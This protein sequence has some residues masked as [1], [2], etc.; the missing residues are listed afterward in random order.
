MAWGHMAVLWSGSRSLFQTGI[1]QV[2]VLPGL[3]SSALLSSASSIREVLFLH[4]DSVAVDTFLNMPS[5]DVANRARLPLSVLPVI[6]IALDSS[7]C[8]P[9]GFFWRG[10]LNCSIWKLLNEGSYQSCSHRPMPQPEQCRIQAT[11][12]TYAAAHGNPRSLTH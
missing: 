10:A 11:S 6:Q 12:A 5:L 2:S 4:G 8:F 3:G 1:L 7:L 9:R